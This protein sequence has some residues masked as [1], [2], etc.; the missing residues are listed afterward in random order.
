MPSLFDSQD[1]TGN[2]Q[3]MGTSASQASINE[4]GD[5]R[6]WWAPEK[7]NKLVLK[8]IVK[9]NRTMRDL[10]RTVRDKLLIKGSGQSAESDANLHG[11]GAAIRERTD[12]RPAV[13]FSSRFSKGATQ[14]A[15]EQHKA[16]WPIGP[17]WN[18]CC[19]SH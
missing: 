10:S 9:T 18:L 16:S 5:Q 11:E 1:V 17:T 19:E 4:T 2:T 6:Q 14:W 3:E 15:R 12:S 7:L 13:R 8:A